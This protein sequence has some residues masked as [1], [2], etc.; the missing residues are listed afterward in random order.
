MNDEAADD[1]SVSDV[2]DGE[3]VGMAEV[4]RSGRIEAAWPAARNG[5]AQ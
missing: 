3:G 5:D 1:H 4:G 2:H